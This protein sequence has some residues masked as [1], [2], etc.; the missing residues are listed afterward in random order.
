MY[1]LKRMRVWKI[2]KMINLKNMT[3]NFE[4]SRGDLW[5]NTLKSN[6]IYSILADDYIPPIVLKKDIFD[7]FIVLDGKQRLLTIH[8]Y[9]S[10]KFLLSSD[11][12]NPYHGYS[13]NE[14]DSESKNKIIEYMMNVVI[15]QNISDSKKESI[16]Y[17]L[18]N[19]EKIDLN[20]E[21]FCYMSIKNNQKINNILELNFFKEKLSD[22]SIQKKF[23]L[24]LS[25]IKLIFDDNKSIS[26][27]SLKI[28]SSSIKNQDMLNETNMKKLISLSEYLNMA[29]LESKP[30]LKTTN[31]SIIIFIANIYMY[32]LPSEQFSSL[33]DTFFNSSNKE[34]Q[35]LNS[36]SGTSSTNTQRKIQILSDY[37]NKN[38]INS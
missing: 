25:G 10:N 8:S 35:K 24:L 5:D 9:I 15:Y 23:I 3:F 4:L 2:I 36:S 6:L 20:R 19:G 11:I 22:L 31:L 28:F 37:I 34:Y 17:N 16:F 38:I 18:N 14:L 30:Y 32:F 21:L 29:F 7:N 27:D 13:F 1:A 12:S 26:P 33:I